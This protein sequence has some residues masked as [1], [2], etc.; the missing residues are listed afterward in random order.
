MVFLPGGK[1]MLR[2]AGLPD[3]HGGHSPLVKGG[4]SESRR[5]GENVASHHNRSATTQFGV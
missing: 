3:K 1:A 2:V 4:H 5:G